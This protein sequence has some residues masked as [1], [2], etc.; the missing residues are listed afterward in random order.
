M[1][2][3]TNGAAAP[4]R[5]SLE[6][7]KWD[8]I[9]IIRREHAANTFAQII[10]PST[11]FDMVSRPE[12]LR[13]SSVTTLSFASPMQRRELPWTR[14]L[15]TID[16]L[17][18]HVSRHPLHADIVYLDP[19]HTYA[20]S[21]AALRLAFD[22]VATGGHVILHDCDP[23]S[24]ESMRPLPVDCNAEWCGSTWRAF[25][26]M[27][28]RF[29]P[30]WHWWVVDSDCGVGV[31]RTSQPAGRRG[32]IGRATEWRRSRARRSRLADDAVRRVPAELPHADEWTWLQENRVTAL[33]LQDR[34]VWKAKI[35][36]ETGPV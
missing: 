25:L 35:A 8:V 31:V 26:D 15:P 17:T 5:Y 23:F 28:Q 1:T 18:A 14:S 12:L 33:R 2:E 7:R 27:T 11:S 29:D 16:E 3:V 19:W 9:D 10:T 22:I 30:D 36:D 13:F 24:P 20:D 21:I 6:V 32:W 4:L 34:A